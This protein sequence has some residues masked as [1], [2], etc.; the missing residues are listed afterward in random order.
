MQ[1]HVGCPHLGIWSVQTI[2]NKISIVHSSILSN[3]N[4][5]VR[6]VQTTERAKF[7][8][9]FI[10]WYILSVFII[11][12]GIDYSVIYCRILKYSAYTTSHC[13][14][15]TPLMMR[16]PGSW[17]PRESSGDRKFA[18]SVEFLR[19]LLFGVFFHRK[20][21]SI[22]NI[23]SHM[24]VETSEIQPGIWTYDPLLQMP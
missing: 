7:L 10:Y 24:N 19:R 8:C 20:P 18:H 17:F 3:V 9:Y 6:L 5:V 14:A 11:I 23:I 12:I 15:H 2:R 22:K 1:L 13:L 21:G 16:E 4:K